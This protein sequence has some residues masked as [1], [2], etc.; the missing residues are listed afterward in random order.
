LGVSI[1][2][3][4]IWL[5]IFLYRL[6]YPDFMGYADG[7]DFLSILVIRCSYAY[8]VHSFSAKGREVFRRILVLDTGLG[9]KSNITGRRR[10]LIMRVRKAPC[11]DLVHD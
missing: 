4:L 8:V 5:A 6:S 11:V 1:T 7:M 10:V 3:S 2:P 9:W